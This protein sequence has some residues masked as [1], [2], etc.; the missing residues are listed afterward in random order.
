MTVYVINNMTI[1]DRAEY[2]AYLR[3]FMP[4]FRKYEGRV[5]AAQDR[6]QPIEGSWPYERTI[7]LSFPSRE[8]LD[9]WSQSPEYQEI[10]KHRLAGTVSNVVVLEGFA[11]A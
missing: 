3:A 7:L 6:P 5:L 8:A 10:A 11:K 9:R 2:D 1:H 4:V